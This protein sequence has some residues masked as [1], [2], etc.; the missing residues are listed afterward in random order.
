MSVTVRIPRDLRSLAC[1]AS[2]QG[3]RIGWTGCGH[4]VW[5]SPGGSVVISSGCPSWM[6]LPVS[7]SL[8]CTRHSTLGAPSC[9]LAA[10][11]C[12]GNKKAPACT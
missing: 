7:G 6:P 2:A 1:Q 11:R 10:A 4:L 9:Q 3:W 8:L 5:R 12:R